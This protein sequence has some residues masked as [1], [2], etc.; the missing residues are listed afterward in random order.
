[1]TPIRPQSFAARLALL[2]LLFGAVSAP[3]AYAEPRP[4]SADRPDRTESPYSVPAGDVQLEADVASVGFAAHPG[5]DTRLADLA[6]LNLKLGLHRV[7]D[8]QLV[9]TAYSHLRV[10]P[11]GGPAGGEGEVFPSLAARLKWNFAGNDGGRFA[12]GLLP[13]AEFARGGG[14]DPLLGALVPVA[15]ELPEGT[16][17]AGMAGAETVNDATS[18]IAS[19]TAAR[20]L[21]PRVSAFVELFG[22]WDADTGAQAE[23]TFDWGVTFAATELVQ[24]DAGAYH[25]LGGAAEDLRVFAGVTWRG[26]PWRR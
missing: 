22:A 2:V 16:S 6:T 1:M 9:G 8:V 11:H 7:L 17:V 3:A 19:V 13:Y 23:S 24:L 4:L 20:E 15:V 21:A 12:L 18:V 10:E 14:S 5:E 25:G 26:R